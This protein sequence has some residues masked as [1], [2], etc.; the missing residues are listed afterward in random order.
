MG[1]WLT[2]PTKFTAELQQSTLHIN[3]F[4]HRL[5]VKRRTVHRDTIHLAACCSGMGKLLE[6]PLYM[7]P[8]GFMSSVPRYE[9]LLTKQHPNPLNGVSPEVMHTDFSSVKFYLH[10]KCLL[11][12]QLRNIANV[13]LFLVRDTLIRLRLNIYFIY[14]CLGH[15]YCLG[16]GGV[17]TQVGSEPLGTRAVLSHSN[18]KCGQPMLQAVILPL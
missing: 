6:R 10:L 14:P 13:L 18:T 9:V 2:Y 3:C 11:I 1:Y 5:R 12:A 8:S 16:G 15:L 17:V 7:L 4:R